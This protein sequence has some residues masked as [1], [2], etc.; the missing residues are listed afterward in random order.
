MKS[1]TVVWSMDIIAA[2]PQDAAGRALLIQ[3]DPESIAT[4]F[5]VTEQGVDLGRDVPTVGETVQV[6]LT[7]PEHTS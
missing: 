3:R 7:Y 6:D 4:C 1:Y 2:T 5:E